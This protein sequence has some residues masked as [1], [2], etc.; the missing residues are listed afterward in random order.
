MRVRIVI[1]M[2]LLS[3]NW[4]VATMSYAM[5][6]MSYNELCYVYTKVKSPIFF[7]TCVDY[8][9]YIVQCMHTSSFMSS[10]LT[11]MSFPIGQTTIHPT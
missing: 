7:A 9:L 5:C 1:A 8:G 2:W 11:T 4:V 3:Y 10:S 6:T